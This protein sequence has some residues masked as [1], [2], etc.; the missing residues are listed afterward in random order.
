MT[1]PG[2]EPADRGSSAVTD[3]AALEPASDRVR[4]AAWL[5]ASAVV[6]FVVLFWRLGAAS[7]WDPDEA[8]YAETTRELLDTGDWLAPYYNDRPFFDK[9]IL[10]HW[11]Q[12]MAMKGAGLSETGARL[13]PALAALA[14]IAVTAWV[15]VTLLSVEAGIVAGLLLA[16]NPAVF[17]LSRYAILDTVFTAFLFG[18]AALVSVAAVQRRPRLQWPGYLLVALAVLTKGP[19]ALVLCGLAFGLT[20]L[21]SAEARRQLFELRLVSG[22]LLVI[23]ITAPWFVLMWLRF[24]DAF[25]AGYLL[26]ENIRLFATDRFGPTASNSVWFYFRVLSAGLLPWTALV[27]GRFYDDLRAA[28]RRDGSLDVV[29][30][31]LWSWTLVIVGFFTLSKF[32]LDHYVFPAA[33]TLCLICARTWIA[34]RRRPLDP[35]NAGARIGLYLIGP[36]MA[37]AALAG[38]YVLVVRL[39]LPQAALLVPLAM[40]AAGVAMTV[41][42]KKRG[43]RPP[44][45]PWIV[46]G[47]MT[48]TYGGVLLWVLPA[49]ERQKVVPDVAR[50]VATQ[51]NGTDRVASYRLNRWNTAFRFY[52]GRHVTMID[53]PDE[54]RALFNGDEPFYCTMLESA[55]DSFVA[56]GVPLRI[57]YERDGMWMT[58][59]RALWRRKL[60]P[61]RFV[62]VTRRE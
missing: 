36:L 38:A 57:V 4:L 23:L 34:L 21:W 46:V 30:A 53:A 3:P 43:A 15:G 35:R 9:P 1:I 37:V 29:D 17:A 16:T 56:A 33:P 2:F 58:S 61:T 19:I 42:V 51:A 20:I 44:S 27:V 18:G 48:I 14:L 31:L 54:A 10:F 60:P 7:F 11:L 12:A 26:D 25:V 62:V 55:Y 22:T 8:H 40:G 45:V 47:A 6:L 32:K 5:A 28:V 13:V 50:W 41:S 52:V 59:G 24:R 49:L 39:E